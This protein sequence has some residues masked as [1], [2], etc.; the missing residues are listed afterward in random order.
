MES[1]LVSLIILAV[2]C[3]VLW[4]ISTQMP[5]PFA[6]VMQIVVVGSAVLWLLLNIRRIIGVISGA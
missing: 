5:Q 2:V 1:L 3:A 4:W 6:K